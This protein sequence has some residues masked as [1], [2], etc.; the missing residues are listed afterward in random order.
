M[1]GVCQIL[2]SQHLWYQTS[3]AELDSWILSIDQTFP[4]LSR[5]LHQMICVQGKH[6]CMRG[7]KVNNGGG[8]NV[9]SG[10]SGK[11]KV[12]IECAVFVV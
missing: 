11:V 6:F 10:G 8:G 1:Y 2:E 3:Q 9:N 12:I 5:G 7:R 4:P